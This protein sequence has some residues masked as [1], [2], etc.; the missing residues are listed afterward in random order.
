M[1]GNIKPLSQRKGAQNAQ[2]EQDPGRFAQDEHSAAPLQE[3]TQQPFPAGREDHQ[4]GQCRIEGR[5]QAFPIAEDIGTI[6]DMGSQRAQQTERQQSTETDRPEGKA[7][8]PGQM[9]DDTGGGK[10]NSGFA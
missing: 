8:L 2:D 4:Q 3:Q 9:D 10:Q 1:S 7:P 5:L 6:V